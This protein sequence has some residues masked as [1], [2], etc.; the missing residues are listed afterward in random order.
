MKEINSQH[1]LLVRAKDVN[2][3]NS[4]PKMAGPITG[5]S[6]PGGQHGGPLGAEWR[7]STPGA[8]SGR[9][10][11]PFCSEAGLRS[12]IP[13]VMAVL[14]SSACPPPP[15]PFPL[16]HPPILSFPSAKHHLLPLFLFCFNS[17][18]EAGP[19][20]V[21]SR[22]TDLIDCLRGLSRMR[23]GTAH[24]PSAA[25]ISSLCVGDCLF[26]L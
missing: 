21:H 1:S 14:W 15:P 7:S 25:W 20:Q 2:T 10:T 16:S 24:M 18:E 9:H 5:T 19:T 23:Y 13:T 17:L 22:T 26:A 12:L 4:E 11:H 8:G 3:A 6:S